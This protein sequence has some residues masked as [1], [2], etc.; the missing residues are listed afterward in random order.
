[1]GR[2]IAAQ[3][4]K[5]TFGPFE[6]AGHL[7]FYEQPTKFNKALADFVKGVQ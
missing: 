2:N 6:D 1:M 7:L 5:A 4:P 3:I